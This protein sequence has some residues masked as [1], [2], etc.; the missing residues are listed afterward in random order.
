ML[1]TV[2]NTRPPH[3]WPLNPVT[4]GT[5]VLA[6]AKVRLG[7]ATVLLCAIGTPSFA[8][9]QASAAKE[10]T[11][12]IIRVSDIREV[13]GVV[14]AN[15]FAARTVWEIDQLKAR[16]DALEKTVTKLRDK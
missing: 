7:Q 6:I 4:K 15:D 12:R 9:V 2:D 13:S 11:P 16:V 1:L 8:E 5:V 3:W 14:P 10:Y